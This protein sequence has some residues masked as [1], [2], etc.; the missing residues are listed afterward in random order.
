MVEIGAV[1]MLAG[2]WLHICSLEVR[3]AT[4]ASL[5]A[6]VQ[7]SPLCVTCHVLGRRM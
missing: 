6:I 4:L 1:P 3:G 5:R 2:F 7:H